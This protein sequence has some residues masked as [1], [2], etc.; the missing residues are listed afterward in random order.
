MDKFEFEKHYNSAIDE[1]KSKAVKISV[2]GSCGRILDREEYAIIETAYI[3]LDVDKPIFAKIVL[4]MGLE[5]VLARADKWIFMSSAADYYN[6][7]LRYVR[8]KNEL[9]EQQNAVDNSKQ[10]IENFRKNHWQL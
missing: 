6:G 10:I 5:E 7:Y 4:A 8:A 2:H 9:E 3:A 1:T